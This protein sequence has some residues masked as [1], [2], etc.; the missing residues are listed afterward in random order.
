[1]QTKTRTD[2]WD[3][4]AIISRRA[5]RTLFQPIVHIAT[6]SI[7]GFEA[8]SRGPAGSP[9]ETA[10]ALFDAARASGRLGELDW[11][12]RAL[13]IRAVTARQVPSGLSWFFNVEPAAL[14]TPCPD[15]LWLEFA[16]APVGLRVFLEIVERDVHARVP[17]IV[18]ATDQARDSSW[19]IALD[20]VDEASIA[21]LPL[22]QPDV[23]KIEAALLAL[24]NEES[25]RTVATARSYAEFNPAALIVEGIETA[26][27]ETLARANGATYGQGRRYG[28]PADLPIALSQPPYVIPLQQDLVLRFG[29][30]P[31]GAPSLRTDVV[32]P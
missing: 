9:L 20:D 32:Q 21:L 22:V 15:D 19:G 1:M 30:G 24:T 7:V 29:R 13:A 28:T 27:Q 23:L 25:K 5:V 2:H 14:D 3:V 6:R 4:D 8:L 10:P 12:C 17:Q 26:E 31:V 11:L 16:R 18:R